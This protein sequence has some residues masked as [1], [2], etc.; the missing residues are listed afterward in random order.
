MK[1][2]T[3]IR[4]ALLMTLSCDLTKVLEVECDKTKA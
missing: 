3:L 4:V 1:V 2:K